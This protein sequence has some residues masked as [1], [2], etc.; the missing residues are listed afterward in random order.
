[1]YCVLNYFRRRDRDWYPVFPKAKILQKDS[2]VDSPNLLLLLYFQT[3]CTCLC[4]CSH[5]FPSVFPSSLSCWSQMTAH[6][7][8]FSVVGES[9]TSCFSHGEDK[10]IW[11]QLLSRWESSSMGSLH[12]VPESYFLHYLQYHGWKDKS[13]WGGRG[14]GLGWIPS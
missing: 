2:V 6:N 12:L 7:L 3:L 13:G 10:I 5:S 4:M 11:L 14:I 1:M 9:H 8:S